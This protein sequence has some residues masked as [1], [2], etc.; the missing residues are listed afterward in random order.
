[1]ALSK[2]VKTEI[3]AVIT[4]LVQVQLAASPGPS[5]CQTYM[6]KSA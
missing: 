4:H 1:M 5:F 3:G 6:E 2:D